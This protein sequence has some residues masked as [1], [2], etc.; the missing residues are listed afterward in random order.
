M[1]IR[2]ACPPP[3]GSRSARTRWRGRRPCPRKSRAR[4][5]RRQPA[6]EADV[7][8]RVRESRCPIENALERRGQR[9][10]RDGQVKPR[11]GR[12]R[13]SRGRGGRVHHLV[14]RRNAGDGFAGKLPQRVRDGADQPAIDVHR[15]AAHSGDDARRGERSALE[16]RQDQAAAGADD[17]LEDAEDVDLE[18]LDPRAFEYGPADSF[19]A[20]S[21]FFERQGGLA[22]LKGPDGQDRQQKRAERAAS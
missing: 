19:H 11:L 2:P 7:V 12:G 1:T 17:V 21:D 20:G 6:A 8:G 18:I 15:A 4:P 9:G 13:S 3:A 14:D 22:G 10:A 16:P 5:A